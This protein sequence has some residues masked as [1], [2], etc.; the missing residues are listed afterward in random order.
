[1][2]KLLCF[3]LSMLMFVSGF[4]VSGVSAETSSNP[5]I[6]VLLDY[7]PVEFDQDPIIIN[8]RTL[9]PVRAIFEAMGAA[10]AWNANTKT[11]TSILGDTT[12]IMVVGN[13]VMTVN[14]VAKS[15]DVPAQ[16]HGDRTLVPVR[17]VSESFGAD[18]TWLPKTRTVK[19]T[20]KAFQ[21]KLLDIRHFGSVKKLTSETQEA[22]V[23]FGLD[24]FGNYNVLEHAPDGTDIS[25]SYTN[26]VG[27][28]SLSVRTD[29][30]SGKDQ[31][32][33][34]AYV[35]SVAEDL[36]AV[37]NKTLV[38]SEITTISGTEFMKI[39]C[40]APGIVHGITDLEPDIYIY[41]T[42]KNGVTYTMTY[43][44][45]GTVDAQIL[46]DFN[47]MTQSLVVA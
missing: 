2:K 21:E 10:V 45:Y 14:D 15:L 34:D 36:A 46:G 43:S 13:T 33:T 24:Y 11:V 32:L 42:R 41:I 17:A 7:A 44:V 39:K 27:H 35:K 23:A 16:I 22:T 18:V 29:L 26:E 6:S 4:A 28:I 25:I 12:V 5:P 8:D 38:S 47:Y 1:M 19:I 9:V 37:L 30:Y 31:A 3:T 40:T 20:S